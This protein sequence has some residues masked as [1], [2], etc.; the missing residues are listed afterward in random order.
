MILA[1]PIR[2]NPNYGLEISNSIF[3]DN[4][5]LFAILFKI[6]KP[7]IY[8]NFQYISLWIFLCFFFQIF[9]SFKLIEKITKDYYFL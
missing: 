5:P 7:I 8:E 9:I 2:K 6:L 3:T 1:F 4:I